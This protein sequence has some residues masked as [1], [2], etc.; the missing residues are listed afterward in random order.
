MLSSLP[1]FRKAIMFRD[2]QTRAPQRKSVVRRLY[3]VRNYLRSIHAA[4]LHAASPSPGHVLL[5]DDGLG[6]V[7]PGGYTLVAQVGEWALLSPIRLSPRGELEYTD[8]LV[9]V[10]YA[11][12]SPEMIVGRETM[13]IP[14]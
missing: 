6:G 4:C 12:L 2:G 10:R 13:I 8:W 5:I 7:A 9:K 1:A 11:D 3:A 14:D